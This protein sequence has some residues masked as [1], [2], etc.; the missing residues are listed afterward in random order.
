MPFGKSPTPH[1]DWPGF[2]IGLFGIL[3]FAAG[4]AVLSQKLAW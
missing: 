1:S 3:G 4:M 2:L